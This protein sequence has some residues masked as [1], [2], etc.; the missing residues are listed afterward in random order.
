MLH[1]TSVILS[2]ALVLA[3][4]LNLAMKPKFSARISTI[5]LAIGVTGGL[6]FYG[7]GWI[8]TTGNLFLALIRTPLSV[9]RM[10]VGV[11]ELSAISE[12][13]LVSTK[14]GLIIF[15]AV[16]LI[17]FYSMASA[18]MLTIGAAVLRQ[19]RFW[20]SLRGDLVLIYGINDDSIAL[21]KECLEKEKC[22]VVY[23]DETIAGTMISDINNMGMSAVEGQAAVK[24]EKSFIR[25]LRLKK[26]KLTVFAMQED[27]DQNLFY[28]LGLKDALE[29]AG[30]PAENTQITL[31][32]EEEIITAMLQVSPQ[33][34]GFGYVNVFDVSTLTS[35]AL[36]RTCPPW[37][38]I[39]F[40]ETG[41]AQEDFECA[42]LGFGEHGQ[43]VLKELVMNGQFEGSAF[44]AVIFSPSFDSESGFLLS[45]CPELL[46]LY[47]ITNVKASAMSQEFFS[48]LE[49][50]LRTLKLIAVCT[51]DETRDQEISD[52]LMLYL[53]RKNAENICVAQCGDRGV[54]YQETVGSPVIRT[55]INT[56]DYLAAEQSDR[57]AILLNDAYDTSDRTA[58]EKWM[59][60]D[61][62]SKMSSR[63]SAD[64]AGAY[65]RASGSSKE[66]ILAGG[67]SPDREM[68]ET[69]GKTEHLR[70]CAFHYTM[71][72]TPMSMAQ[73]EENGRRY[74][75]AKKDGRPADIRITKDAV[76]RRHACLIPWDE[77]DALSQRE[78][79]L[80][81]RQADYK[82]ADI[83]NVLSLPK[84][85]FSATEVKK[86]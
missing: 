54:R 48:F 64:F 23:V 70:W 10:F 73:L 79:E 66:E 15:W 83:N 42:I 14:A 11:N 75:E 52:H 43:A 86:P 13:T 85:L 49:R 36:I 65:V 21:G 12:S 47:D 55:N 50:H 51:G 62:F 69:L 25:K 77:L 22:A 58:W 80:T 59:A 68:L 84:L 34:Y 71:G 78:R 45:D 38:M 17:A 2:A 41:R 3:M 35:R 37:E 53:K 8:E 30:I 31:P 61:S 33:Q 28:A 72:Y 9:F 39:R 46:R 1:I 29:E 44:R 57:E 81:G 4:V 76:Q 82:Q 74:H 63:A 40:D 18:A 24:S 60:C 20:L 26:R 16:H 19:L 67:W 32:G 7:L 6:L 27:K 5:C 56:L